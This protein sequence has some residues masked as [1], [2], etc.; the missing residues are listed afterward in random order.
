VGSPRRVS[1]IEAAA[2]GHNADHTN[3]PTQH[4][5]RH[6]KMWNH[7]R[8]RDFKGRTCNANI[9]AQTNTNDVTTRFKDP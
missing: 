7:H 6:D 9:S 2:P 1:A 5:R 4:Q 8:D 3:K